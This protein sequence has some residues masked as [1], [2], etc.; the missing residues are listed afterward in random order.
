MTH[1]AE[2]LF[3]ALGAENI[4]EYNNYKEEFQ[5][6]L[7]AGLAVNDPRAL[8]LGMILHG[9]NAS[10]TLFENSGGSKAEVLNF[11]FNSRIIFDYSTV[12]KGKGFDKA[13]SMLMPHLT[14]RECVMLGHRYDVAGLLDMAQHLFE[15]ARQPSN[16]PA[17][18][19]CI[20][21]E[22]GGLQ[23]KLGHFEQAEKIFKQALAEDNNAVSHSNLAQVYLHKGNALKAAEHQLLAFAPKGA[24]TDYKLGLLYEKQGRIMAAAQLYRRAVKAGIAG[25]KAALDKVAPNDAS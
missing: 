2:N 1:P 22:L 4:Y 19:A 17:E 16:G 8:E 15:A 6:A 7:K 25:A 21:N 5:S 12:L 23:V 10:F 18:N 24:E 14:A 9:M 3:R 20:F 13:L 11:P